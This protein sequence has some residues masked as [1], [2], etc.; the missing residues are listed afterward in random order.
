MSRDITKE[1]FDALE[2]ERLGQKRYSANDADKLQPV[3]RKVGELEKA[4]EKQ[5]DE[6]AAAHEELGIRRE[7]LN[8]EALYD[9]ANR[10]FKGEETDPVWAYERALTAAEQK[11]AGEAKSSRL[12]DEDMAAFLDDTGWEVVPPRRM[13]AVAARP[14]APD[15][16]VTAAASSVGKR[17]A[18]AA[19]EFG[20]DKVSAP[21]KAAEPAAPAKQEVKVLRGED[22][23]ISGAEISK[24]AQDLADQFGID[25]KSGDF[26]EMA[27]FEQLVA[28]GRVTPDEMADFAKAT[29]IQEQ[30]DAYARGLE[31]ATICRVG[32]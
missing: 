3:E 4:V 10:L 8:T 25:S 30:T 14:D 31:A 17:P 28:M 12:S 5:A 11:T 32:A 24:P 19:A 23:R 7:E 15:P 6:I 26:P 9:A 21:A 29:A 2:A 18:S 22:G 13:D 1:L 20:M 16:S 27:E